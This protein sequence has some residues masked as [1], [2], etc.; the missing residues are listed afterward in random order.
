MSD[1]PRSRAKDQDQITW[2]RDRARLQ[3]EM[4]LFTNEALNR[5]LTELAYERRLHKT[6][7]DTDCQWL[8]LKHVLGLLCATERSELASDAAAAVGQEL[9]TS[10]L[11]AALTKAAE[12]EQG[13]KH[14]APQS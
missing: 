10:A 13:A 5:A 11:G 2:E 7:S 12:L 3:T 4:R 14:D 1:R 9:D 8:V 6:P